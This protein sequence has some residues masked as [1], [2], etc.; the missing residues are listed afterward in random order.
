MLL[1]YELAYA[2]PICLSIFA[3]RR[4]ADREGRLADSMLSRTS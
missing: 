2:T 4:R 3:I 1:C